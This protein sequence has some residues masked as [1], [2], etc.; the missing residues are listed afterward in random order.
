MSSIANPARMEAALASLREQAAAFQGVVQRAT[1]AQ[2]GIVGLQ[3]RMAESDVELTRA[4][5]SASRVSDELETQ[6]TTARTLV[7]DLGSQAGVIARDLQRQLEDETGRANKRLAAAAAALDE[8]LTSH[9]KETEKRLDGVE[10]FLRGRVQEM[11]GAIEPLRGAQS[12]MQAVVHEHGGALE[13]VKQ[14]IGTWAS[15]TQNLQQHVGT[16]LRDQQSEIEA[17]RD[18]LATMNSAMAAAHS[19]AMGFAVVALLTAMVALVVH[20]A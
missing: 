5:T 16:R 15:A 17:L 18:K 1:E 2:A 7:T 19:R 14:D 10:D 8:E 6:L 9:R 12:Q 11:Q 20:A 4:S 3:K 13:A